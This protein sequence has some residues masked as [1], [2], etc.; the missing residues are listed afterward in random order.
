MAS[1]TPTDFAALCTN[2]MMVTLQSIAGATG[3][4]IFKAKTIV[5]LNESELFDK[6]RQLVP[7]Y[8]GILYEGIR[9]LPEPVGFQ[10]AKT[11][12]GAEIV[13]SLILVTTAPTNAPLQDKVSVLSIL[14]SVR[15]A[16]AATRSPTGAFWRF[17]VEAPAA[18][19]NGAVLW[20]QRWSTPVNLRHS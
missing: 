19:K 14:D 17:L 13:I 15:N 7:P 8:T 20:V 1:A 9:A 4:P 6:A 12:V 16:I 5:V 2:Q 10:T 3:T 18:E 11:G